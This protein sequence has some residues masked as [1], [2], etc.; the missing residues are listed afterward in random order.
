MKLTF[1]GAGDSTWLLGQ[2]DAPTLIHSGM[3]AVHPP[4]ILHRGAIGK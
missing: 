4:L 1:G 2:L 3:Q